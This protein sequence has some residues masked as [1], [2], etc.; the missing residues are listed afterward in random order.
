[1]STVSPTQRVIYSAVALKVPCGVVTLSVITLCVSLKTDTLVAF[2]FFL[3]T[4]HLG[5]K[6]LNVFIALR[7]L[8]T[9][10]PECTP[11]LPHLY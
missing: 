9:V 10:L 3:P 4:K 7:C 8:Q 5:G 2:N 1:M 6:M 11:L